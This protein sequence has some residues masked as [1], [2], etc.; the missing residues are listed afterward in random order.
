MELNEKQMLKSLSELENENKKSIDRHLQVKEQ[1][2]RLR[3]TIVDS[4]E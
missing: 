1:A 2:S 3:Q 4:M